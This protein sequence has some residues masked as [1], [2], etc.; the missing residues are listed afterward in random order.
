MNLFSE[1]S[2]TFSV[3]FLQAIAFVLFSKVCWSQDLQTNR[4]NMYSKHSNTEYMFVKNRD[5]SFELETPQSSRYKNVTITIVL[6]RDFVKHLNDKISPPE[7]E[8]CM[9]I[10][11]N[12]L[13]NKEHWKAKTSLT[14][15]IFVIRWTITCEMKR[16]NNKC[17]KYHGLRIWATMKFIVKIGTIWLLY[18]TSKEDTVNCGVHVDMAYKSASRFSSRFLIRLIPT[19]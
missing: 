16:H 9:K 14:C 1:K 19:V 3:R 4:L 18:L 6:I 8:Q 13:R 15:Y 17:W 10:H 2:S 5:V 11:E 12:L 7:A